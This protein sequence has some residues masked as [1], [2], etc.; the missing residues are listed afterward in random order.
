[1]SQ[2]LTQRLDMI[3]NTPNTGEQVSIAELNTNFQKVDDWLIPAAKIRST[4]AQTVATG[5]GASAVNFDTVSYDTWNGSP[6]GAMADVANERLII[7]I[8]GLYTVVLA[9]VFA[10]NGTGSRIGNIN[11]NGVQS[12]RFSIAPGAGNNTYITVV[13]DFPL[14]AGD[15]ITATCVQ[16]SGAG[17]D[18]LAPALSGEPDGVMLM[19]RWNGK[20]P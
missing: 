3:L 18:L 16:T 10:A 20:K 2:T 12:K 14:V 13:D 4:V 8:D 1:M 6:E 11:I 19:A 7:R 15:L 17:L 5:A 9:I